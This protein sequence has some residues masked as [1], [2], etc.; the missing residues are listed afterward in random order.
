MSIKLMSLVW[1]I[2]FPTQ[3]QKMIALKM[4]DYASD[5]G[6]S[7][8]PAVNTIAKHASCDER[9]VQR[10][11][12]AFRDCGLALLIKEGGK[13]GHGSKTTNRWALNVDALKALADGEWSLYG[14]A[15]ELAIDKREDGARGDI[16]SESGGDTTP[17]QTPV[18]VTPVS[19][20]GDILSSRGDTTPPNPSLS[21]TSGLPL[22]RASAP[23]TQGAARSAQEGEE[24]RILL[25]GDDTWQL[26]LNWLRDQHQE[27]A[28]AAF[29]AEGAMVVYAKRP[30]PCSKL[31]VLAPIEGSDRR[32]ALMAKRSRKL[33]DPSDG[34]VNEIREPAQ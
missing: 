24:P 19:S 14:T 22:V 32:E 34:T 33:R 8:F 15:T 5:M 11:L 13:G 10:V 21:V 16:L 20:R 2:E 17:P 4:A 7:I 30:A 1:D 3:S 23:A 18:G 12:K 28:A 26:W 27:R 6:E 29:E 9:T 31:P 25:R